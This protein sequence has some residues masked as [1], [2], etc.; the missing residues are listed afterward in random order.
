MNIAILTAEV[1]YPDNSGGRRYTWERIKRLSE[2]G[3]NIFLYSIRDEE[4]ARVNEL[5]LKEYC[6]EV[7]FYKRNK[8]INIM[9]NV[10]KPYSAISRYNKEIKKQLIIDTNS[11]KIDI[12]IVDLPQLMYNIP[13]NLKIPIVLTQHNIEYKTFF[14]ISKK[15]S[16]KIKKIV[17]YL[18]GIRLKRFEEK[19]YKSSII[20]LFTFISKDD[21]KFFEKKYNI[22]NT[23]L[24]PMGIECVENK[25]GNRKFNNKIVFVGKMSYYPNEEAAK[26]FI[27]HIFERIKKEFPNIKMYLVGKDPSEEIIN[28]SSESIIV[29]GTVDSVNEF[30][31][32]ADIIVI[33]LLSGGGVKIKLLEALSRN[34][35]VITTLKGI[36]GTEFINKEHVLVADNEIDFAK[37]CIDVLKNIEDYEY[38]ITNSR[39]ILEKNYSWN[40]IGKIYS[41]SFQNLVNN[42][43]SL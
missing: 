35:I 40:S 27:N 5:K 21:K 1:P 17:Y 16:K 43:R 4:I 24:I 31:D 14:N 30:I 22:Y 28:L 42:Y 13:K 6:K 29:T 2:L 12:V 10:N 19:F 39:E 11:K 25:L 37:L 9:L 23:L 38:L 32:N 7:K 33:P 36:E 41:K 26:W 3:N 34:K 8:K 15:S 18:E 20:K